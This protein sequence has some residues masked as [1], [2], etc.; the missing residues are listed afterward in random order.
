MRYFLLYHYGGI[1]IDL[2]IFTYKS[3]TP[4]LTLPAIACRTT[5][6]GISNDILF[7][8]PKHP[9]FTLIL[10]R[11]EEYNRNLL[12]PYLTVMYTTGPLFL[13]AI[14]IEYLQGN[15][16]G[17]NTLERLHVLIQGPVKGD[18]YGLWKNIKGGS[19]HKNDMY[20]ILWM[21]NHLT[22]STLLGFTIGIGLVFMLWK[23]FRI[24]VILFRSGRWLELQRNRYRL[25][26]GE[27]TPAAW[28]LEQF[29]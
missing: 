20:V 12:M 19:W 18:N 26:Q 14:W 8:T 16:R 28:K 2:D 27:R 22:I 10:Q 7:S 25:R 21:G 24:C 5:P 1:Y 3:L 6:T 29:A 15:S 11:L 9:F 4:L 17:G 23:A 13:S